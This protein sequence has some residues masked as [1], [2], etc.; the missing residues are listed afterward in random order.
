MK[1]AVIGATGMIGSRTVAEAVR[2]GHVVDAYSR[3][4]RTAMTREKARK[5]GP[6]TSAT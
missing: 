1:I 5:A 4:G 6:K 2:R 3:S